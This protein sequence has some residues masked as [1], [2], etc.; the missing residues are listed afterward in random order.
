[1]LQDLQGW[2]S[3]ERGLLLPGWAL[4]PYASGTGYT[5]SGSHSAVQAAT[6]SKSHFCLL[7]PRRAKEGPSMRRLQAERCVPRL[8]HQSFACFSCLGKSPLDLEDRF[9][10]HLTKPRTSARRITAWTVSGVPTEGHIPCPVPEARAAAQSGPS[11]EQVSEAPIRTARPQAQDRQP[12]SRR[13]GYQKPSQ[14]AAEEHGGDPSSPARVG[15]LLG[16]HS[17]VNLESSVHFPSF[18]PL[19]SQTPS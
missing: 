17:T 15:I 10:T 1:M 14:A 19:E 9:I 18:C 12:R 8:S 4:P 5:L 2:G 16:S 13:Q 6:Q 11:A 7:Y 3:P